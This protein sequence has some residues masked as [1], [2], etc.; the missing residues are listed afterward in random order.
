MENEPNTTMNHDDDQIDLFE[1]MIWIWKGRRIIIG[2]TL[3]FFLIGIIVALLSANQYKSEAHLLPEFQNAPTG[4]SALLRQFGGLGGFSLPAGAGSDA[5]GPELYPRVLQ[6]S[7]FFLE[8]L[9]HE[10][11]VEIQG[12][13]Q[14]M[15]V[16]SYMK[17]HMGNDNNFLGIVIKYTIRLPWTILDL[18][19][20]NEEAAEFI[21]TSSS[22]IPK[23]NREQHDLIVGLSSRVLANAD[24]RSGVITVSAEF[25]EPLVAAQI[26]DF[27]VEYLT[28]Y[29]TEYRLEKVRRDLEFITKRHSEKEEEFH[30]ARLALARFRDANIN[31]VSAAARTE[32]QRLQDQNNLAFNIYNE[33]A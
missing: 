12:N 17:N 4:A 9:S 31:I 10:I 5:I 28:H 25:P 32:E 2:T 30:S 6:S 24:I 33:L 26:A 22:D 7:P 3:S 11:E 8:L 14:F 18:F 15:S 29:I 1:I 21:S 13:H 23:L 16:Y 27:A 20:Q 19:R